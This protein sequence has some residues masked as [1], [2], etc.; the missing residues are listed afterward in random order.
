ME[1]RDRLRV[2]TEQEGCSSLD[3]KGAC[4][5]HVHKRGNVEMWTTMEENRLCVLVGLC[6]CRKVY[7]IHILSIKKK[8][9]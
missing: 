2:T 4:A 8:L 7:K 3:R 1:T 5:H 9:E 6:A